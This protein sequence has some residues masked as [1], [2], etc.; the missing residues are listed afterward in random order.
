MQLQFT[1]LN[2]SL[3]RS[4]CLRVS[5]CLCVTGTRGPLEVVY[6]V[7]MI[8][9]KSPTMISQSNVVVKG[10]RCRLGSVWAGIAILVLNLVET[11]RATLRRFIPFASNRIC[12]SIYI[13]NFTSSLYM[14]E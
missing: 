6:L 8:F 2:C 9:K 13:Y 7:K 10:R 4:I 12:T 5:S 3:T 11:E 1:F 14:A